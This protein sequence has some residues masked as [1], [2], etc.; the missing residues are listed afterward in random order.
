MWQWQTL[1]ACYFEMGRLRVNIGRML[2]LYGGHGRI[3][4]LSVHI[5][6][7]NHIVEVCCV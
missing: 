6:A 3:F 1:A 7:I 4:F 5:G 2:Q